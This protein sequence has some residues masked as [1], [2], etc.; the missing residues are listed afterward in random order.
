MRRRGTAMRLLVPP[1]PASPRSW[2]PARPAASPPT[3]P[4]SCLA[5]TGAP[6]YAR[7]GRVVRGAPAPCKY[8]LSSARDSSRHA[9]PALRVRAF[10][11]ACA[12]CTRARSASARTRGKERAFPRPAEAARGGRTPL[13]TGTLDAWRSTSA[14]LTAS[15]PRLTF[16][17]CLLGRRPRGVRCG[18][19]SR[20]PTRAR[21]PT[22]SFPWG[23]VP[24]QGRAARTGSQSGRLML[25]LWQ[26]VAA[27]APPDLR[28][29]R[30]G[31]SAW[32]VS[33]PTV[34]AYP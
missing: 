9:R 5:G 19:C 30:R 10:R 31:G 8:L 2:P 28:R 29:R 16:G 18:C 11:A 25:S 6:L 12:L 32:E 22:R 4:P 15:A 13:A 21:S 33:F 14:S 23:W 24:W 17:C 27:S 3:G 20:R 7:L 34:S 1:S 26:G